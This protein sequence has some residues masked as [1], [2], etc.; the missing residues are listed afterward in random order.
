MAYKQFEITGKCNLR[1]EPCYNAEL[2]KSLVDSNLDAILSKVSPGDTV[3]IGGGEPM[4]HP[5]IQQLA[6]RLTTIPSEVVIATN[7]TLYKPMPR[8]VQIQVSVWTLNPVLYTEILGGNEKL[9]TKTRQTIRQYLRDGNPLFLNLPVYEKNVG[10]IK[11]VSAYASSLNIP[12][13]VNKIFPANGIANRPDL[14]RRIE[15]IIFQLKCQ[16]RDI[17]YAREKMPVQ[18]FYQMPG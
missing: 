9:L 18:R 4:L 6:Q 7:G 2:M 5:E 11:E 13:R 15:D 12:L 8:E 3:Y 14:Q 16:G 10:E 1:C 17:R